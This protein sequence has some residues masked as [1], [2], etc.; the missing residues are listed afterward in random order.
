MKRIGFWLLIAS[1][2]FALGI[3]TTLICVRIRN[4]TNPSQP[5][6]KDQTIENSTSPP[7]LAYCEL[8][9]NPEKYDGKIVHLATRLSASKHGIL[10]YDLNCGGIEKA[11]SVSFNPDNKYAIARTLR[12]ARGSDDPTQSVDLIAVGKLRKVTPSFESD[13][14][15][16]T[17]S[18][19]FE[20]MSIEK[21]SPVKP[22]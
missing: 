22:R 9:N 19:R 18:L 3:I 7:V 15:S 12:E 10:F 2:S 14:I 5:S 11:A 16:D 17:T 13:L 6:S 8:A 20:I 21:A 1:L 4:S